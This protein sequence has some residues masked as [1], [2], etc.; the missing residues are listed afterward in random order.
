MSPDGIPIRYHEGMDYTKVIKYCSL[1]CE[2]S[3]RSKQALAELFG[4]GE[5]SD[6]GHYRMRTTENTEIIVTCHTDF[7][8]LV[9]QNCE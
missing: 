2:L 6:L 8:L 3:L 9:I 5:H 7:L 1:A 4:K